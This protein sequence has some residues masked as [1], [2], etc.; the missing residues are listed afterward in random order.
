M[1]AETEKIKREC[2][3]TNTPLLNLNQN[4]TT[5]PNRMSKL[6]KTSLKGKFQN[7][8]FLNASHEATFFK[9]LVKE[10]TNTTDR[11]KAFDLVQLAKSKNFLFAQNLEHQFNSKFHPNLQ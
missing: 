6:V 5:N 10:F 9:I 3:F 11:H 7:V 2:L 4:F 8:T 1:S